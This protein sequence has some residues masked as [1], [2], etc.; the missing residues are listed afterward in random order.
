MLSGFELYPRW[1]PLLR[2]LNYSRQQRTQVEFCPQTS[3]SEI[4]LVL[5]LRI[6]SQKSYFFI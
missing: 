4:Y 1:V 2:T 5:K 3:S 6:L